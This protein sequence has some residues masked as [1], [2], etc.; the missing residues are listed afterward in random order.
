MFQ[1]AAAECRGVMFAR[2]V[3]AAFLISGIA[4]QIAFLSVKTLSNFMNLPFS[5]FSIIDLRVAEEDTK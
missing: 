2:Y 1:R 4:F 5:I 3:C